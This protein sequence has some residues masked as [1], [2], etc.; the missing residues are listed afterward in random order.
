MNTDRLIHDLAQH[1]TP[2]KRLETPTLRLLKWML[3]ALLCVGV[4]VATLGLRQDLVAAIRN[5]LYLIQLAAMLSL[6]F[7]SALS[8]LMLSVPGYLSPRRWLLPLI[9]LLLWLGTLVRALTGATDLSGGLG[10]SCA[11][12][13]FVLAAMPAIVLAWMLRKG[14]VL[15][16]LQTGFCA[17]IGSGALGALA[18]QFICSNDGPLHLL[19]W[20]FAPTLAI[21]LLGLSIGRY[22]FPWRNGKN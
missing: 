11:R 9:T 2:V 4:G 1:A 22:L 12:D 6:A 17:L 14:A 3:A 8:A 18:A 19:L 20:H 10:L 13:I 5:P 15:N 7:L 16:P 21:G